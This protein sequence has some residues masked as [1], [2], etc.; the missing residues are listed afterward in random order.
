MFQGKPHPLNRKGLGHRS[1]PISR[2]VT[3]T[4]KTYISWPGFSF[5]RAAFH[6]LRQRGVLFADA[7]NF[8]STPVT[9]GR[10]RTPRFAI[11]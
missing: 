11:S 6:R 3:S 9:A 8:F 2:A 10:S 4:S 7:G 5:L 1:P